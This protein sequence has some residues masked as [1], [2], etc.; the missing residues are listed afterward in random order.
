MT[1]QLTDFVFP[2]LGARGAVVEI[3]AG[4]EAMLGSREYAPAVRRLLG[5]ALAATPLLAS[6]SKFDGRINLQFQNKRAGTGAIQ[7]LV[8]QIDREFNLRGMAKAPADADGTFQQLMGGGVLA[9]MLEPRSGAQNY[10]AL[11][12]I[13]GDSL[14]ESL[15]IYFAHSEQLPTLLRLAAHG[16]RVAGMLLQ[17][18]PQGEIGSSDDSWEHLKILFGT[19]GEDEL[20]ATAPETLLRR[21]FHAE[22]LRL[23]PPRP[24]VLSCRCSHASISA[25]LLALGEAELQPVLEEQGKI[26]VTCEFCGR[27]Y[28]YNALQMRDL[29]AAE[30]RQPDASTKLN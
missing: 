15:E 14:A 1:D 5:Q 23:A 6:H 25:M 17:R 28:S 3:S 16:N 20:G 12:E 24:I 22:E 2:Q 9:L 27:A 8:T 30:L 11:V 29:F 18:L 7:L 4:V 13:L 10:Q 21:L 26:D 19:L